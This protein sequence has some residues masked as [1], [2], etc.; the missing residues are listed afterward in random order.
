MTQADLLA[1]DSRAWMEK[2]LTDLRAARALL[3]AYSKFCSV[4][5]PA[6][7]GEELQSLSH[8]A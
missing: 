6:G 7:D 1:Q 2:A 3:D 8:M 5:L 4:S